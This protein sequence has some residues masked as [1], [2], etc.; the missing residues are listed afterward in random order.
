MPIFGVHMISTYCVE[1]TLGR[2]HVALVRYLMPWKTLSFSGPMNRPAEAASPSCPNKQA[3]VL[4]YVARV[5]TSGIV[6]VMYF[7]EQ[8]QFDSSS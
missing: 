2:G 8:S 5:F 6:Y 4:G 1:A 3:C 7:G